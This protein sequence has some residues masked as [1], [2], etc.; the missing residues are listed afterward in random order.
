MPH[1]SLTI[2]NPSD[3]HPLVSQSLEVEEASSLLHV[4]II[5]PSLLPKNTT[6]HPLLVALTDPCS[7]RLHF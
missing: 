6:Y 4:A 1:T 7:T 3:I 5:H 2:Y